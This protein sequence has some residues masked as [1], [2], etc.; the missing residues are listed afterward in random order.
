MRQQTRQL[1]F[2]WEEEGKALSDPGK[3]LPPP[4]APDR[5]GA[6]L[7]ELMEAIVAP[8]N[9]RQAMAR[10]RAN[11]GSPGVDGMSAE[12]LPGYLEEQGPHLVEQLLAGTHQPQPVK[13]AAIPKRSGGTRE[14]GIPTVVDRLIQQAIL[15]V[16]TPVYDPH[17][18]PQS[19]GF[20]PGK[21]AHQALE[22]ARQ[23]VAEGQAWVVDLRVNHDM[24]MGRLA[25]RITDKRLLRLIRRYLEAGILAEGV[26]Q[27]REEGTP[28]GG[29]LSPLLANILL[30]DFDRELERRG[31]SFCRFADDCNIYVRSQ[32]AGARVMGSVTRYLETKLKLKVNRAKSRVDLA[33]KRKFLGLRVSGFGGKARLSIA[34]ESRTR[35]RQEVRRITKRNRGVS[36]RQVLTELG[37]YPDGWVAYFHIARTPSVFEE[38]DQWI[39]RR[40][41]CYQWKL[42][43]WPKTRAK[44]LLGAKIGRYLAWGTAY[45]TRGP[46]SVAGSP[47]MTQ[48]LPNAVLER[49]GFRSLLRRYQ[50]LATS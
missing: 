31:H 35:L 23:Y 19:Y 5:E 1:A 44:E 36:L 7:G 21:N 39:R 20:R 49:L 8:E 25:K 29:P 33:A 30:D 10:V 45:G 4:L 32:R 9:L 48:A 18:S 3:G 27:E 2:A 22:Q 50:A 14:L 38:F 41:R 34:L 6:L 37:R 40:L 16:L 42:W 11:K 26:V 12:R 47:A 15:Q 13:R 24:L 17:F 28:Q 43:K 46:W